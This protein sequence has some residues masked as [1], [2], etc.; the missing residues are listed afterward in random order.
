MRR[1]GP[2][3]EGLGVGPLR[4]S[5]TF[6]VGA[7]LLLLMVIITLTIAIFFIILT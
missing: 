1:A 3:S 5:Q 6:Q 4:L 7:I 2:G